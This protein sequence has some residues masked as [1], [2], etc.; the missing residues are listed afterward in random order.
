MGQKPVKGKTKHKA[1]NVVTICP[2]RLP[3][4]VSLQTATSEKESRAQLLT[5]GEHLANTL[6]AHFP[7]KWREAA[8]MLGSHGAWPHRFESGFAPRFELTRARFARG[9]R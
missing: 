8:A 1:Q 4:V 2:K 7:M 9:E 6:A 5:S 3:L